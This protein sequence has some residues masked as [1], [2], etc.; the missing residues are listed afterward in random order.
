MIRYAKKI[1]ELLLP[2]EDCIRIWRRNK[3][4]E[5]RGSLF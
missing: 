2:I 4:S 5:S 1:P 3:H